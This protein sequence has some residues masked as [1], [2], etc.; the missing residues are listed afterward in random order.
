MRLHDDAGSRTKRVRVASAS[1]EFKGGALLVGFT[2]SECD[3]R[4]GCF[5]M[6]DD[7]WTIEKPSGLFNPEHDEAERRGINHRVPLEGVVSL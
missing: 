1:C 7:V 6:T 2:A 5:P 4:R 3:A